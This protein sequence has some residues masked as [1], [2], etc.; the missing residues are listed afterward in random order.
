M[1]DALPRIKRV[2]ES[3]VIPGDSP[4]EKKGR[5]TVI[6]QYSATTASS[7]TVR[8]LIAAETRQLQFGH[9]GIS[10]VREI[11]K[12][13]WYQLAKCDNPGK[14]CVSKGGR[15]FM[16]NRELPRLWSDAIVAGDAT[17]LAVPVNLLHL[18]T[19]QEPG[20][21]RRRPMQEDEF[22]PSTPATPMPQIIMMPP[23]QYQLPSLAPQQYLS[24]PLAELLYISSLF[25]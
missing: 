4:A 8:G 3:V 20:E 14:I 21:F 1:P 10:H 5:S 2:V 13:Y 18:L 12:R 11:L 17:I 6:D 19:I 7:S 22:R 25:P 16:F 24:P 15:H 9:E 23:H